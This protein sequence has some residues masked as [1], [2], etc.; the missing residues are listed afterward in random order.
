MTSARRFMDYLNETREIFVD[1]S[2][3]DI[4]TLFALLFKIYN[5]KDE[6]HRRDFADTYNDGRTINTARQLTECVTKKH[7]V[8]KYV[9]SL[10]SPWDN[11]IDATLSEAQKVRS[12]Q[13]KLD[14]HRIKHTESPSL[15]FKVA[16]TDKD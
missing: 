1:A 2:E 8:N 9:T 14:T 6:R 10:P 3:S 13:K 5:K 11:N 15:N 7:S 4:D 16:Y 12:A